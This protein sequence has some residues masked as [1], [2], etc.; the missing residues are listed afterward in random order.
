MSLW[1]SLWL[2]FVAHRILLG[3]G[4]SAGG[5]SMARLAPRSVGE[6]LSTIGCGWCGLE[7]SPTSANDTA[8]DEVSVSSAPQLSSILRARAIAAALGGTGLP[9]ALLKPAMTPVVLGGSGGSGGTMGS[10]SARAASSSPPTSSAGP[11]HERE[12]ERE[13]ATR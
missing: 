1:L 10:N 9:L 12:S 5:S 6:I 3:S 11:M 13:G 2:S 8:E 7:G 4:T